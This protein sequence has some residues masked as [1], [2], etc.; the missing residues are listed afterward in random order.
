MSEILCEIRVCPDCIIKTALRGP[1][2]VNKNHR[3]GLFVAETE[4][5]RGQVSLRRVNDFG[6]EIIGFIILYHKS[7]VIDFFGNDNAIATGQKKTLGLEHKKS[8]GWSYA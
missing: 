8:R 1:T 2:S 6:E 3:K 5:A 7:D 4:M